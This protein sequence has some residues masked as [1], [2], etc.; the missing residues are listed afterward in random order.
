MI[1]SKISFNRAG[2]FGPMGQ[3]D[4]PFDPLKQ[5]KANQAAAAPAPASASAAPTPAA[6][7]PLAPTAPGA[8]KIVDPGMDSMA[9]LKQAAG[10]GGGGGFDMSAAGANIG[11]PSKFRQGIG[12]RIPPQYSNSLAALKQVY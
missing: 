3:A 8:A 11:G 6:P 12:N 2:L 7:I 10:E 4:E 5:Q 1:A 9:G